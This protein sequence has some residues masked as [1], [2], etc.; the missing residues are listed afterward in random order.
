MK[1]IMRIRQ[2]HEYHAADKTAVEHKGIEKI[3]RGDDRCSGITE[4]AYLRRKVREAHLQRA[5]ARFLLY[6]ARNAAEI[7]RIP[8]GG[9]DHFGLARQ[10]KAAAQRRR[11][12]R[13]V[14]R[15]CDPAARR[16]RGRALFDLAALA[17]HRRLIEPY[18]A[19]SDIAVGR[20]GFARAEKHDIADN[21]IGDGYLGD[22]PRAPH[23][24]DSPARLGAEAA[25]CSL[26]AVLGHG[27]DD[28]CGQ[29]RNGDAYRF[30]PVGVAEGE[31]YIRRKSAEQYLYHG[32]PEICGK[33]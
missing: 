6:L 10:H 4:A 30:E 26:S 19:R 7:C 3:R 31:N 20:H 14:G 17:G 27:G 28:G 25:V 2:L 13:R 5:F 23:T 33:A 11:R 21:D 15:R 22:K 29:H 8:H 32:V 9:N 12:R 24:A 18:R 1:E 16:A